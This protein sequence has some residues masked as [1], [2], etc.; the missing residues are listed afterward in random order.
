MYKY[1]LLLSIIVIIDIGLPEPK[2]IAGYPVVWT[3]GSIGII[4][5]RQEYD[6][7]DKDWVYLVRLN[8]SGV[9]W[10]LSERSLKLLP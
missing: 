10:R 3:D 5:Q 4:I 9:S 7:D 8:K 2:F 6:E 1:L